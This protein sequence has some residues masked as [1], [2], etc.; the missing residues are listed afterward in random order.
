MDANY[1]KNQEIKSEIQFSSHGTLQQALPLH[2]I[3][4]PDILVS[5]QVQGQS[6]GAAGILWGEHR[7]AA[8]QYMMCRTDSAAR[9][10]PA[11]HAEGVLSRCVPQG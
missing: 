3:F 5:A 2:L 9:R 7:E 4:P 8:E 1:R 10:H 6:R 11:H